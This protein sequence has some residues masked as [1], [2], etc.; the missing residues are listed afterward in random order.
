MRSRTLVIILVVVLPLL[1]TTRVQAQPTPEYVILYV[2]GYGA[3]AVLTALPEWSNQKAADLSSGLD[4]RLSPVLGE[5]L[6][7]QGTLTFSLYLRSSGPFLG[8]VGVQ[9]SEVTPDG[10]ETAVP[11]AK[12]D[13][14]IILNSTATVTAILGVG[15]I[16]YE[17]HAG[18]AIS[19]HIGIART[20][21]SGKPLLVWDSAA[22][23]TSV[24]IPAVNPTTASIR[25]SGQRGFG[26]VF[27]SGSNG[28]RT[29]QVNAN[30]TDAIGVYRFT[31]ASARFTA[32]NGT[33]I[34]IPLTAKNATDYTNMYAV[35]SEFSEGPWLVGLLLF[36]SSGDSYSFT[37]DLWVT[38]FYSVPI[39]VLGSDG[40][41][42]SNATLSASFGN[43]SF[44]SS[45]TNAS[46]WGL[47]SLPSTQVVGPLN[48]TVSWLGTQTPFPQLQVTSS[49]PVTVQITVYNPSVL[50]TLAGIPVPLAHVSLYQTHEVEQVLTGLNGTAKFRTIPGGSYTVRVEYFISTY[51]A[52]LIVSQNGMLRIPLPFPH[53]TILTTASIAIIALA[54]VVVVR[55]KRGKLYPTDFNYFN[56]LTHGGL[57][58]ACFAVIAGNSGSGKSVLLNSLAAEHLSFGS[59]ICITNTEYPDK[60]RDSMMR[61]GIA[62]PAGAENGS[63]LI[64]ID[65]YSAVGGS[66]SVEEFSVDSHTDLTHLGLN[67]SKCLQIAGKGADVYL[68][69]LNPLISALRID[70]LLN[71]LQS[72]AARVKA[73][74]GRF[75]VTVG[76]GIDARDMTKLE[77]AADCVIETQ[78]QESR[79]G[80]IR[81]LRVKK[82]RGKPYIDR[83]T[84]FRVEQGKGIVFLIRTKPKIP[85]EL[86]T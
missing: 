63:R 54:S 61:L 25:Y 81:R 55:R 13:T 51:Q 29:I 4:F 3:S 26:R 6:Q 57:P 48:L 9:L 46:G 23:P 71:F 79:G 17:F 76:A 42:L 78:L 49:A 7:I 44:W 41:M 50:V 82:V 83:W 10:V 77:E 30:L 18:S 14:P 35:R 24:K 73:A 19:L 15:I 1:M 32:P 66:S 72:V 53:R 27:Q 67:I 68:D 70:Y 56:E 39:L 58:D 37:N 28:T 16:T 47:L 86:A 85:S 12:V 65:A 74:N 40:S 62:V 31:N 80:Q 34:G 20:S 69:S 21:G 75:C 33:N 43:E 84:R 60:V 36:D 8:T 38:K 11:G 59:S 2:H 64:F 52:P 22:S 45:A 5:D